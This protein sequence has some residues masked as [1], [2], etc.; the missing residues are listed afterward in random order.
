MRVMERV[1]ELEPQMSDYMDAVR[2]ELNAF[3]HS[4]EQDNISWAESFLQNMWLFRLLPYLENERSITLQL[5][6]DCLHS[7]EL[8]ICARVEFLCGAVSSNVQVDEADNYAAVFWENVLD[9]LGCAERILWPEAIWYQDIDS[10]LT[11]QQ[12]DRLLQMCRTYKE[13]ARPPLPSTLRS[14]GDAS[15]EE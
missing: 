12:R 1:L 14:K 5:W 10:S 9:E 3:A 7:L 4:V 2:A 11:Q 8:K 6:K 15:D 13:K